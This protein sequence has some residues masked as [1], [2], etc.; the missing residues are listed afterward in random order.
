MDLQLQGRRVLVTGGTRG[1]GRAIAE[2]FVAEGA[3]VAICARRSAEVATAVKELSRTGAPA[4]GSALDVGDKAALDA[5]VTDCAKSLGGIDVIVANA[6]GLASKPTPDEF[7]KG[8]D[9]DLMHT[10][11]MA[12]AAMPHLE[13]SGQGAIIAIASISGIE[14]YGYS[15]SAYGALKAALN[16]YVKSLSGRVAAKGIRANV[17]SPGPIIFP[18]GFWDEFEQ[19]NPTEFGDVIAKNAMGRM[20]K[21]E[22]IANVVAFLASPMASYVTGTNVVVDGGHTKRVQN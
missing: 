11:N 21:P 18:G 19:K 1:I 6:S 5:W 10:V 4:L 3:R 17:V 7:R 20:G 13:K 8:F 15:E 14:D 22:E 9:V 2:R 16:F 12:H